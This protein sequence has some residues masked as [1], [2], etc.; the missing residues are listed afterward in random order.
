MS[1]RAC[2]V[3]LLELVVAM[4]LM[5]VIV[6]TLASGYLF[7]YGRVLD[8]IQRQNAYLQVDYA[9][10]NIRL[11]CLSASRIDETSLFPAASNSTK[12]FFSFEGESDI[13]NITPDNQADNVLYTYRVDDDKNL[14]LLSGPEQ[15]EVLIES[16]YLPAIAFTYNQG[17]EPNFLT[18][19]VNATVR[20]G[21]I[22]KTEGLRFWFTDVVQVR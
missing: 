13:H 22:S 14:V 21:N 7:I 10:E 18:V 12:D 8:N 20:D 19:T 4:F 3:T 2:G 5:V 16:Q 11:H 17:S 15:K 1:K 6:A 9:L